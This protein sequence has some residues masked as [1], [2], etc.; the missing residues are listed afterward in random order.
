MDLNSLTMFG[1]LHEYAELSILQE[2]VVVLD[3]VGMLEDLQEADLIL[4]IDGLELDLNPFQSILL[5]TL[6]L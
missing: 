6:W 2:G 4:R 1:V 3:D 5:T